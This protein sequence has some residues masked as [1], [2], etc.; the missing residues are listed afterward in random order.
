[1]AETG[2]PKLVMLLTED[3]F[4]CSHFLDRALAASRGGY[5]VT[6]LAHENGKAA[7]IRAAGIHFVPIPFQ[8]RGLNPVSEFRTWRAI[9][10]AYR[11]L[12]PT[13]VHQVAL[14]PLLYGS[15][16]ARLTGI[17]AVV[18]APVGMGFVFTSNS[19]KSRL[20]RPIVWLALRLLM[21][22]RGSKVVFENDDDLKKFVK[23]G[24]VRT[25]DAV[26]IRGAGVNVAVYAPASEPPGPP[27]VTLVARMLWDKGIGDFVA[28]A[29]RLRAD[30][31][32][33]IFRLVGAPDLQNPATIS[34]TQLRAW[35]EE[36]IVEWLGQRDDVPAVL[37]QSHIACLPSY[38]EGLPKSL[39]EAMAAGL[40]I[41]STDVP[42]CRE[43]VK[44]GESGL[45]VPPR[46]SASLASAL[47]R[48]IEDRALRRRFGIA[49][50]NRAEREFASSIVIAQ[51]L[52]VY[53]VLRT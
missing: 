8:R 15:L 48:L 39:L 3:W 16:A 27:V 22:P 1:M 6:V 30:G 2:K 33:A 52:A 21:N 4:F 37:A 47:R 23:G 44:H 24:A 9:L 29:R 17:R 13:L 20:L 28:A 5:E 14:K 18:N 40:P 36:G 11:G 19:L 53:A 26:L 43:V 50:R 38:R 45:L 32:S 7:Q 10:H 41:V 31:V 35:H 42:G 46:D 51:T 34:E 12:Q 25:E 49:G